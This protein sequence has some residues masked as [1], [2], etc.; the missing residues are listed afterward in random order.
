MS[1]WRTPDTP[2]LKV[3]P[4][5][6]DPTDPDDLKWRLTAAASFSYV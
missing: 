6:Y 4:L 3:Q 1:L 2:V 5:L